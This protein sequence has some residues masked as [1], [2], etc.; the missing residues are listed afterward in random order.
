MNERFLDPQ[1]WQIVINGW[2]GGHEE[3]FDPKPIKVYLD[4]ERET[5]LGWRR[6]YTVPET[7]GLLIKHN[8]TDLS[9]DNDLGEDGRGKARLEGRFVLDWVEKAVVQDGYIPPSIQIHSMNSVAAKHMRVVM[10]NIERYLDER[11]L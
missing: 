2:Y 3:R 8:V 10:A 6:T 7:I 5:P 9:L 11:N 1:H 4:D